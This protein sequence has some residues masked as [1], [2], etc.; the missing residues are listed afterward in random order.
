M[1]NSV[2]PPELEG[3]CPYRV[4]GLLSEST[5]EAP[6]ASAQQ[7]DAFSSL[8]IGEDDI[9]LISSLDDKAIAKAYRRAALRAHPD[10][11][12]G[13][14]VSAAAS[15]RRVSAAFAFLADAERRELYIQQL[16]R[17]RQQQEHQA[18]QQ[19]QW[20]EQD[21]IRQKF[22][23]ELERREQEALKRKQRGSG[24]GASGEDSLES[25][26]KK[27]LA[28]LERQRNEQRPSVPDCFKEFVQRQARRAS[29]QEE[30]TLS[31][32][33]QEE[34]E[35]DSEEDLLQRSLF[36]KWS[37]LLEERENTSPD[38]GPACGVSAAWLGRRL[39]S[40]GG[41]GLFL[42]SKSRACACVS[43][44]SRES[45]LRAALSLKRGTQARLS[46]KLAEKVTGLD[47]LCSRLFRAAASGACEKAPS[48]R[49]PSPSLTGAKAKAKLAE[50]SDAEV[51]LL[52]RETRE[53][54]ASFAAAV[55][56]PSEEEIPANTQA[57]QEAEAFYRDLSTERPKLD[58]PTT[59]AAAQTQEGFRDATTTAASG[60][61]SPSSAS[62]LSAKDQTPLYL[63]RLSSTSSTGGPL[64]RK[65]AAAQRVF[66]FAK[67][68]VNR[69]VQ[70]ASREASDAARQKAAAEAKALADSG[71]ESVGGA[72]AAA[73]MTLEELEAVAF[74]QLL[75]N[76]PK[77]KL[78]TARQAAGQPPP[79][80]AA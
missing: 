71:W 32:K 10:K 31:G 68:C 29:S 62:A 69:A 7:S 39:G 4:L 6:T 70:A 75:K 30:P 16:R 12:K 37:S 19:L 63:P 1:A 43:F 57:A 55:A 60:E 2:L 25:V 40:L 78:P 53:A 23:D 58:S 15:F 76:K 26:R 41:V 9:T 17:R 38:K 14:E 8:L 73:A 61:D 27:T 51:D 11:N 54:E 52:A 13:N 72:A 5:C 3:C 64:P 36:L 35:E 79:S 33:N 45:A 67:A 44:A 59:P 28:F 42:F 47:G 24:E 80:D 22:K 65:D 74:Q 48:S 46:A 20:R 50:L 49:E 34:A 21:R 56:Q 77:P 18:A 66:D